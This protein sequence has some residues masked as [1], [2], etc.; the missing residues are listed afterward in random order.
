MAQCAYKKWY[1]CVLRY[2]NFSKDYQERVHVK[3][4]YWNFKD[5]WTR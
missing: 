4:L 5:D 2:N 3:S 1:E